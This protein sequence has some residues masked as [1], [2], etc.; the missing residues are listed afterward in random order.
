MPG[1]LV[2]AVLGAG[3]IAL[4]GPLSSALARARWPHR[5]PRPA[6]I[7][8]QAV[9]LGAGLCLVGALAVLA[10]LPL[11]ESLVP[12]LGAAGRDLLAGRPLAGMTGWRAACALAAL[13]TA[14]V[15]LAVLAR[16]YALA[17]R[18][19]RAHRAVLD[20]LSTPRSSAGPTRPDIRVL[21]DRRALAYTVPGWHSR[22]VLSAGLLDLLSPD[23][24]AA[25]IEHERAHLRAR[26][27]LLLL[28]FQAWT[29]ALGAVPGVRQARAAVS[30]LAEMLADDVAASRTNP[31]ALASALVTVAL[32][33]DVAG[34]TPARAD[35]R[36]PT[37]DAEESVRR[38]N[39]SRAPTTRW[40]ATDGAAT[41]TDA[42]RPAD[43]GSPV[44]DRLR[45]LRRPLPLPAPLV[46]GIYA[47]AASIM[48]A[49]TAMV[50]AGW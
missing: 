35:R 47:L 19:R 46:A 37:R 12:A 39:R 27:D 4:A 34:G 8:W 5:A 16:C 30:E 33:G 25:V 24:I 9:C 36:R 13:A 43:A 42:P 38:P 44:L 1:T 31:G 18:R 41:G 21:Q 6:L 49:P 17:A 20:L 48:T 22:V 7:L 40:P 26:H 28:P 3:G 14:S 15:L 29:T 50:I 32:D 11:G 23:E 10:L 2:A 45:R